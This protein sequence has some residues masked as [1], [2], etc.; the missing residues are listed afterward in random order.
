M[1]NEI[2]FPILSSSKE[3]DPKASEKSHWQAVGERNKVAKR[4]YDVS[5][6]RHMLLL[7][8]RWPKDAFYE[9]EAILTPYSTFITFLFWQVVRSVCNGGPVLSWWRGEGGG[10]KWG[11]GDEW[12]LLA[13]T[14]IGICVAGGSGTTLDTCHHFRDL[15]P[16]VS[17]HSA[18]LVEA[19]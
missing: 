11:G 7:N 1:K 13:H 8:C 2:T 19:E 10:D 12:R 14:C 15:Y 9:I 17:C 4:V 6:T 16:N 18:G 5:R 3:D